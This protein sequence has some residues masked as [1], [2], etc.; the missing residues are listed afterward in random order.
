MHCVVDHCRLTMR[1]MQSSIG[2]NGGIADVITAM[3][4]D[5]AMMQRC[6]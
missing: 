1:R 2:S 5:S 4:T 6:R 3:Q